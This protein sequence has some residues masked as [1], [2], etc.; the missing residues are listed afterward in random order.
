M[1]CTKKLN[2]IKVNKSQK[3]FLKVFFMGENQ[4][5]RAKNLSVSKYMKV[6]TRH[7]ISYLFYTFLISLSFTTGGL[8]QVHSMNSTCANSTST[9]FQKSILVGETIV[10]KR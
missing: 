7:L 6:G 1:V 5:F 9:N 4:F 3:K 10:A 2:R 8:Q